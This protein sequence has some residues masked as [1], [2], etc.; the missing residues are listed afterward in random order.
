MS[1]N[2]ALPSS[3]ADGATPLAARAIVVGA[4]IAGML[5]AR[6]VAPHA[7]EVIVLDRDVFEATPGPRRMTPQSAHVHMLL[8]GGEN[9][10]NR[11]VPGFRDAIENAGSVKVRAG[12]DFLGG[13][14]LGF[15]PRWD[16]EMDL[17]AQSRWTLE[18][19]LREQVLASTP[20]VTLRSGITVRGLRVDAA[21][22]RV[23][24]VNIEGGD[25]ASMDADIVIDASGRG[26]AALRW[27]SA[28][29]L[30]L[31]EIE[32]VGVDFGYASAVLELDP[33]QA[34]DWKGLAMGNLPRV[35]ARGAVILPIENGQYMV[36]LGGRAG[37]YPP[38]TA[39][40]IVE[41]AK[42]LP[43]G[44]MHET[45]SR[46]KF[47]SPVA[48][49]IYPANRFRH[50][51]RLETLPE[52]LM[53]IGDAVCSFNPTYGQGM[54]SAA[55]QAEALQEVLTARDATESLRT[56]GQRYL[57]R[58]AEVCR[59]PWR[60]ANYNDFLYPTTEGDREMFTQEEL[61]YRMQVQ[62]AAMRD[63][64]LRKLS[65][66]VGQLLI[67]FEALLAPEIREKVAAA[68]PQ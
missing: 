56:I 27:L 31:P 55:M 60:Q 37:D 19:C 12:L 11:M 26:E 48:R 66:E 34:R 50:Y 41:Y 29:G 24:G 65:H 15:G 46:A 53:P 63:P 9:A 51:E 58:A 6:V 36:A 44:L 62:I 18:H 39:E 1:S 33:E 3:R 16:S 38:D 10:I 17:H 68:L 52:G 35:G 59:M 28:L 30:A 45:L 21:S 61:A 23:T 64:E 40:G 4:S 25:D 2:T 8:K 54:S 42:S 13:S 67:P 49:L 22:N 20:N 7:R 47:V 5:A 43:Q 14:E 57:Q 32:Q